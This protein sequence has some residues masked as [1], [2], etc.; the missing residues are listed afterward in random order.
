M[1]RGTAARF[2]AKIGCGRCARKEGRRGMTGGPERSVGEHSAVRASGPCTERV[3]DE[4]ARVEKRES[5]RHLLVICADKWAR[6]CGLREE[7]GRTSTAASKRA[8]GRVRVHARWWR[9]RRV[10]GRWDR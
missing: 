6:K 2:P 9:A 7:A 1:P 8:P 10:T 4:W 3:A 5:A